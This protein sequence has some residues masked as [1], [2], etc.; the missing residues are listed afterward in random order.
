MKVEFFDPPMCCSTGICGPSVDQKLVK[1]TEDI[2]KLK[3]EGIEVERY[4]ISQ[5]PL[6]FRENQEV[7]DLVKANGKVVLPITTVNGKVIKSKEYP[8][9]EE[10]KKHIGDEQIG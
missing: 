7:Y 1:L 3:G 4:M 8:T 9:Y 2:A 5:Q 6:K 10:I